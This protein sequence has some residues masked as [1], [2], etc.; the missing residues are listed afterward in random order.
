MDD[1]TDRIFADKEKVESRFVKAH[2]SKKLRRAVIKRATQ[3]IKMRERQ[4]RLNP[5]AYKS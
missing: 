2:Q 5:N 3:I 4:E 1:D